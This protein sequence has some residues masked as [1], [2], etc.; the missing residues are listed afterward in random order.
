MAQSSIC[1]AFCA[2]ELGNRAEAEAAF[3]AAAATDSLL[4]RTVPR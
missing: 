2:E 1:W 3:R 4:T